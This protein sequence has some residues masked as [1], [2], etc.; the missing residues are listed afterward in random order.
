M[1]GE[2]KYSM[3]GF[4]DNRY[5]VLLLRPLLGY[6]GI[7]DPNSISIL[8]VCGLVLQVL[9]AAPYSI[10]ERINAWWILRKINRAY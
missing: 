4:F 3:G 6:G 2:M 10:P 5:S 8:I 9:S 7:C 1:E